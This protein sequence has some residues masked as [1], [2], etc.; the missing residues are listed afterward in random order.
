MPDTTGP[1]VEQHRAAF[2]E[3]QEAQAGNGAPSVEDLDREE[4]AYE[5]WEAAKKKIYDWREQ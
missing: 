4:K 3:Y 2:E 5:A 1:N